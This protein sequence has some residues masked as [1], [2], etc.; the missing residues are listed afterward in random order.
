MDRRVHIV[1][2]MMKSNLDQNF[3][4]RDLA[5]V[6]NLSSSRLRDLF[7][8]DTGLSPVRYFRRVRMER[9]KELSADTWLSVKQIALQVGFKDRSHFEREFKLIYGLSP[10][11]YRKAIR[12]E[13]L[14]EL[15]DMTGGMA[16]KL[17]KRLSNA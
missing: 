3:S 14:G 11:Q 17:A 6:V 9:A 2:S 13:D 5:C 10:A 16:T 1:I 7:A 8:R 15:K 4:I 12:H